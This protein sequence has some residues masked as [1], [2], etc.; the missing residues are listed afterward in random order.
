[1]AYL[2]ISSCLCETI[3]CS[4]LELSRVHNSAK[5]IKRLIHSKLRPIAHIEKVKNGKCEICDQWA[6]KW[7]PPHIY[8]SM[9]RQDGSRGMLK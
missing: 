5:E 8:Y 9:L 1:M 3:N 2:E 6:S 4:P 7:P